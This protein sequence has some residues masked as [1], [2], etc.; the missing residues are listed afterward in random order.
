MRTTEESGGRRLSRAEFLRLS[1]ATATAVLLG[2][3]ELQSGR[4]YATPSFTADP[5]SLGVASGDPEHNSVVLWTRLAPEPLAADGHG[6]MPP[7]PVTVRYE[8]ATDHG[9]RHVVHDGAVEAREELGQS[10]HAEVRGFRPG[11]EYFYRFKAGS[12][13]SPVGCTRTTPAGHVDLSRLALAGCQRW[14]DG[15]YTAY[16]EIADAESGLVVFSGDY[17]YEGRIL[18]GGNVSPPAADLR[19]ECASLTDY[20]RRCFVSDAG[21]PGLHQA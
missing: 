19:P 4:A 6:G 2:T 1:G 13:T 8:V 15:F 21:V 3:G 16:A 18:T 10:V 9:F 5:F 12:D 17:I 7:D 14:P 11:F 20:R